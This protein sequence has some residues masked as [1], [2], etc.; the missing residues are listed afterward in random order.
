ML[1]ITQ[2]FRRVMVYGTLGTA[3]VL[4]LVLAL[5]APDEFDV[6]EAQVAAVYLTLL[7]GSNKTFNAKPVFGHR[8]L[9]GIAT[10]IGTG[11]LPAAIVYVALAKIEPGQSAH[12]A[13]LFGLGVVTSATAVLAFIFSGIALRKWQSYEENWIKTTPGWVP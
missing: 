2:K 3:C 10:F 12:L 9:G 5:A 4:A 13:T 8:I 6:S 11:F 7:I 1:S